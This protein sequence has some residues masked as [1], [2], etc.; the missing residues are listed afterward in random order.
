[1]ALPSVAQRLK[2]VQAKLIQI[3]QVSQATCMLYL[4]FEAALLE[5]ASFYSVHW[6]S[7]I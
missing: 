6:M 5:P 1:M 4:R 2:C 3:G 7:L